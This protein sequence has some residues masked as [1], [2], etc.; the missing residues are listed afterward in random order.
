MNEDLPTEAEAVCSYALSQDFGLASN[1]MFLGID[2]GGSTSDILLLAK[3]PKHNNK[4]SL[5]RES[6]VRLASGVFFDAIIK[7]ESF[8]QALVNFHESSQ[9]TVYVSNIKDVLLEP[10]KAPYYLNN[11][12]DQLK[13][14]DD[15]ENFYDTINR[16]AKFAFTIP[17]YVTGLLLFYSGMLI[18]KVIKEHDLTSIERVDILSF[19]KGGR[20]FHWLR[21]SAGPRATREY[22][23]TCLNAGV[24]VI[25]DKE[26]QVKYHEEIEVD[27]KAE[28]AKGLCDPKDI[29]KIQATE[30]A[31]IC[32]EVGVKY[33]MPD[34]NT[35][36]IDVQEEL[37]GDRF[38]EDMNNFDFSGVKNFETFMNIFIEFVSQKTKLYPRADSELRE[39]LNDLPSKIAAFICNNDREYKKAKEKSKTGAGFHYHQP[40]IIAEG[41]CFLSTL[42]RKAFNQ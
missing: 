9:K 34:G 42:I 37:T 36:S 6:S 24:N 27:N 5:Y 41:I 39:D 28:V 8:R 17:A 23:S 18:G 1:N 15:Y 30:D 26:L 22:Y 40:I 4:A 10:S 33:V 29:V 14:S 38:A 3:N 35:R 32:G 11:I 2:V 31:D 21:N 7:S 16:D 19:G 25:V 13:S 12:F 20:I